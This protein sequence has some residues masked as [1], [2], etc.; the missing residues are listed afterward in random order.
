MKNLNNE[1]KRKIKKEKVLNIKRKNKKLKLNKKKLYN[2]FKLYRD[3]CKLISQNKIKSVSVNKQNILKSKRLT[4]ISTCNGIG[5]FSDSSKQMGINL[6][7]DYICEIDKAA[8][9]TYYEN[10]EFKKDRHIDDINELLEIIKKDFK[11]DILTQTPPCQSFSLAGKRKG[12][13]SDNGNLFLTAIKLQKKIEAN[14]VIYENVKGLTSHDKAEYTYED[15]DG[16]ITTVRS[17]KTNKVLEKENLT[18]ID[19]VDLSHKSLINKNYKQ[20]IGHTLHTIEKLL[21]E[22]DRYNYYWKIINSADQGMPQNRERIFIIGIKKELD[23]NNSFKFPENID[24]QFKVEDI[25]EK[26]VADKYFYKNKENHIQVPTNQKFRKNKIYTVSKFDDTLTYESSRRIYKPY[27]APCITCGNSSKFLIEGRIRHLTP[28]ENKRIH[29]F[30]QDFKFV[31]TQTQINKQLGNTVSPGVYMRILNSLNKV[32]NFDKSVQKPILT[33]NISASKKVRKNQNIKIDNV[34]NHINICKKITNKPDL[35]YIC[36]TQEK[37]DNYQSHLKNGGTISITIEKYKNTENKNINKLE[38]KYILSVNSLKQLGFRDKKNG[39]YR[40][41]IDG[42]KDTIGKIRMNSVLL[43]REGGKGKFVDKFYYTLK[44]M[45][46]YDKKLS[47]VVDSFFGGGGITLKNIDKLEFDRYIIN[48]L[49]PLIYKTMLAIKKNYKKVLEVYQKTN[50]KYYDLIS[51]ELRNHAHKIIGKNKT[52]EIKSNLKKIRD[53]DRRYRDYYQ[54]VGAKLNNHENMDIYEV[55]GLF[56]MFNNKSTNGSL[57][58]YEDGSIILTSCNSLTTLNDKTE[59]IKHWS[60]LLNSNN[61]EIYNKDVFELLNDPTI[62]KDGLLFCDGPYIPKSK[63]KDVINYDMDN[64]VE[65]Q[66]KLKDTLTQFSNVIYCNENCDYLYELGLNKGFDNQIV[67]GRNNS[68]GQHNKKDKNTSKRNEFLGFWS[69][70][71]PNLSQSNNNNYQTL[72]SKQ[73]A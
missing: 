46:M 4:Y 50:Q 1:E 69:N 61:V 9:K 42:S 37:L 52:T 24:I 51:D 57:K 63:D 44:E 53:K 31:G 17:K 18:L 43:M 32:V 29:K 12:L 8:N 28:T 68:L 36:L 2:E 67:Y 38:S 64:S 22:D 49:E 73:S 40:C 16:N 30:S 5:A 6:Q 59:I 10:N 56:I 19:T 66:Y 45:D 58:Y 60:F 3:V 39:I 41:K 55:A 72:S 54:S 13:N 48:D 7:A 23:N 15:S 14:I 26:N 21:L 70:R 33:T 35:N 25:L 47:V 65:F 20:T 71:I 11:T 62:P 34:N 27:V